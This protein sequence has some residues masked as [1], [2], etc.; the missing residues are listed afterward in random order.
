MAV[1]LLELIFDPNELLI[2]NVNGRGKSQPKPLNTS[3]IKYITDIA[4]FHYNNA[5][6][7]VN[8][9]QAINKAINRKVRTLQIAKNK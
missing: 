8:N 1:L 6:S 7:S 9:K 5:S 4:L 3:K 2:S